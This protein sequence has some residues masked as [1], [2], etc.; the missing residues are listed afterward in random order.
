VEI[1]ATP[2]EA[3]RRAQEV[4]HTTLIHLRR[5]E[6]QPVLGLAGGATMELL[7]ARLAADVRVE[8]L[9]VSDLTFVALDEYVGVLDA[10]RSSRRAELSRRVLEPWGIEEDR[11]HLPPAQEATAARLEGF[12]AA[13]TG[14][15]GVD[16][17]LLG[18]GENG[19]IGFNEPGTP[20][21]TT[22]H[23]VELSE[24]TRMA[25]ASSSG[26]VVPERAVTHGIAT[27]LQARRLMLLATGERKA[28]AVEAALGAPSP[29]C[30]A[31][32]LQSHPDVLILVDEAAASRLPMTAGDRKHVGE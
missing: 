28:A 4:V 17:Q 21:D 19:H 3:A 22:T 6:R 32:A 9:P 10:D 26:G 29:L 25:V 30:P 2:D 18:L 31:S 15:G 14:L 24:S 11:L 12:D 20:W 5:A 8:A 7:Y 13:I 23:L 1:L 16:L 27:I